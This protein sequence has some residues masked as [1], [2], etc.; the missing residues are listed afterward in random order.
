M[1]KEMVALDANHTWEVMPLSHDKEAI[2]YKWVYKAKHNA[3]GFVSRYKARLVSKGYAQTYGIDYGETFS[4]NCKDGN[5]ESSN[6]YG[7]TIK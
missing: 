1:H 2:G 4:P 5:C 7:S 6:C 3:N